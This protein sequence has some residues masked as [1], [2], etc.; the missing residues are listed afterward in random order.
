MINITKW[1]L[2]DLGQAYEV[3]TEE[4]TYLRLVFVCSNEE[5][6]VDTL[7]KNKI[8]FAKLNN[9]ENYFTIDITCFPRKDIDTLMTCCMDSIEQL[10]NAQSENSQ[11][12][13][14][15]DFMLR[16]CEM[17]SSNFIFI[18]LNKKDIEKQ[19]ESDNG[20]DLIQIYDN[21]ESNN[22]IRANIY[23]KY[24]AI[25]KKHE[26]LEREA[27]NKQAREEYERLYSFQ[28]S[29]PK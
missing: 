11:L 22:P 19:L 4:H 27:A 29:N 7:A 20:K 13:S 10:L 25:I 21:C 15:V 5:E 17:E 1:T 16:Y 9:Y 26:Q 18:T 28:N 6:N 24:S 8:Q 3:Y 14:V 23:D 2:Y 12:K